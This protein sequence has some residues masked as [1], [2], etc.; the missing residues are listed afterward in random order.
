MKVLASFWVIKGFIEGVLQPRQ[1]RLGVGGTEE[2]CDCQWWVRGGQ[3]APGRSSRFSPLP[4]QNQAR[5]EA[6]RWQQTPSE[7]RTAPRSP[8]SPTPGAVAL[9]SPGWARRWSCWA[10]PE[11]IQSTATIS[12]DPRGT[13]L[14]PDTC[15]R[16]KRSPKCPCVRVGPP[17][18]PWGAAR[19]LSHLGPPREGAGCGEG[20]VGCWGL[21]C[22][23][24]GSPAG[25][26]WSPPGSAEGPAHSALSSS[27]GTRGLQ[28]DKEVALTG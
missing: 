5:S 10:E 22:A 24:P 21:T 12:R 4:A 25:W 26:T 7:G 11:R 27:S 15:Q 19:A 18:G 23:T 3:E 16:H 6:T 14:A 13:L 1:S 17:P 28:G 8:A 9:Q 20:D 2:L